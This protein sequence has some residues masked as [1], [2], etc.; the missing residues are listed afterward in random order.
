MVAFKTFR[1][2]HSEL[3]FL[4]TAAAQ[5]LSLATGFLIICEF[6][7]AQPSACSF[8]KKKGSMLHQVIEIKQKKHSFEI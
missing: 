2:S 3:C 8:E 5:E 7:C 1:L 6:F 4:L